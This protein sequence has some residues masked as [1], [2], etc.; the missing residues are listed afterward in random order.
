MDR[1]RNESAEVRGTTVIGVCPGRAEATRAVADLRAA[2][3]RDDQLGV[4]IRDYR[5]G[6]APD[7]RSGLEGD[8]T[9]T[10][11]EEGS[12]VGAAVGGATGLGLGLAVAAGAIPAIG[13]VVA[14]GALVALLASAGAGATVG[15]LLG[16]LAGL[17]VPEDDAL[18]Y[19]AELEAGRVLVTVQDAGDGAA[20]A[21]KIIRRH[22]TPVDPGS[23]VG[24][25]GTG[26]PAT[27]Y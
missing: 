22:G 19:K 21:L 11:W 2:G 8:T 5:H 14:G 3:F 20:E 13:P 24:V 10:R 9:Y 27:P 1:S 25:Y 6:V 12:G 4:I 7:P 15:A 16:A 23:P 26:L 18:R 17:G